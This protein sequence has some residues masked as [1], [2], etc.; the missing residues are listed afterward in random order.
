MKKYHK[1]KHDFVVV[2]VIV[3]T[4]YYIYSNFKLSHC[5][6]WFNKILNIFYRLCIDFFSYIKKKKLFYKLN[7][8]DFYNQ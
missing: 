5:F 6:Y 3:G 2:D 4:M 8:H 1:Y 7:T